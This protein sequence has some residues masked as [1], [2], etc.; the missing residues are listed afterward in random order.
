MAMCAAEMALGVALIARPAGRRG[1]SGDRRPRRRRRAV[2]DRNGRADRAPAAAARRGLRLLGDLSS[3]PVRLRAIARSA[4]LA[5]AAIA[6]VGAAPL[7]LPPP[8]AALSS[9]W[10]CWPPSSC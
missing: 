10:D 5:L 2:P 4:L 3:T 6:S 1:P 9:G 7:H 8:G